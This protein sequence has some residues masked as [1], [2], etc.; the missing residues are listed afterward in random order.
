MELG[1]SGLRAEE[2]ACCRALFVIYL[3][4]WSDQLTDYITWSSLDMHDH[5]RRKGSVQS[6][7]GGGHHGECGARAYN[8]GL[9]A[10]PPLGSRG[11]A[12]GEALWSWKHFGHWMSNG[13]GKFSS[14]SWKQYALLRSTG[15]RVGGPR[16]H[17][18]PTPSLGGLC[19]SPPQLRRLCTRWVKKVNCC[20]W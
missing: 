12:P 17:G 2:V 6:V 7:V 16:V 5:R 4:S 9:G 8:G 11:R 13:A 19:P 10:E 15:V 14:S 18:A 3:S 20:T 1:Y